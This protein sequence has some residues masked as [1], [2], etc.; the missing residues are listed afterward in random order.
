MK[1]PPANQWKYQLLQESYPPHFV[2][3]SI[4]N[5]SGVKHTSRAISGLSSYSFLINSFTF[6]SRHLAIS[7]WFSR[8]GC[9]LFVHHLE[10]VAGSF[11]N[12]SASHLFVRFFSASTTFIRF[13]SFFPCYTFLIY[14]CKY[15]VF[16]SQKHS[17]RGNISAFA[18]IKWWFCHFNGEIL[19]VLY[20]VDTLFCLM[21]SAS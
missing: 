6:T 15:S 3:S 9:E 10:T 21:L 20:M 5:S 19:G 2:C 7:I 17:E 16:P 11:L 12:C 14:M 4:S 1:I 8:L 13:M 18:L